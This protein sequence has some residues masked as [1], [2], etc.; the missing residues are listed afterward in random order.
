MLRAVDMALTIQHSA[1]AQRAGAGTA[2][3]ARPEVAAQMFA[4]KLEKQAKLQEQQVVQLNNAEKNDVKGDRKG[5]GSGYMANR[6]PRQKKSGTSDEKP[7]HAGESMF[8][9][10]V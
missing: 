5:N 4:D 3:A 6:K 2:N 8:D 9:I 7:K 1:D 10:V